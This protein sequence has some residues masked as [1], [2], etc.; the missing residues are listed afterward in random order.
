MLNKEI[1]FCGDTYFKNKVIL[2]RF[3]SRLILNLEAPITNSK[4]PI[5]NK[6]NLKISEE[7]FL[8]TFSKNPPYAVN[9]SNNHIFDYGIEGFNNTLNILNR[10]NIAYFGITSSEQNSPLTIEK[11]VGVFSYCCKATNPILNIEDYFIH[12]INLEKIRQ[13]LAN[14][15]GCKV[16]DERKDGGYITPVESAGDFITYISRIRE[17]RTQKNSINMWIVSDNLLKGAA[18][19]AVQIATVLIKKYI[20]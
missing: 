4:N 11:K 5:N 18:L 2:P 12:E 16:H 8:E 7:S 15:P 3:N 17:D 19:N 6:V 9:L 1:L 14:A 10:L 13:C 20:H